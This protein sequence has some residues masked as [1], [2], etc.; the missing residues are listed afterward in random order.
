MNNILQHIKIVKSQK[1]QFNQILHLLKTAAQTLKDRGI[2]QWDYWLDPPKER[3]EWA[4]EGFLN[5]E[6]YFINFNNEIIGMYRLCEEDL[7]YWGKQQE[8]AYYIH[9]LVIHPKY[10]GF[11][12]GS[13]II[14]QIEKSALENNICFMRLDCN[15]ANSGLCQYYLDQGF[16]KVG[17]KQMKLSLNSLFEKR[18]N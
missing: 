18:L 13:Y 9:S 16:T 5:D 17:E 4:R 3:L 12:I 10:K 8:P 1:D 15:A 11:K 14:K 6:F 7:L 2:D